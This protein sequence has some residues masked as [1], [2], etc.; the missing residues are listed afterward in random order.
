VNKPIFVQQWILALILLAAS[1]SALN[2]HVNMTFSETVHQNVTFAKDFLLVENRTYSLIEG[3]FTVENPGTETVFDSYVKVINTE[4]LV[5]DFQYVSGRYGEQIIFPK[6]NDSVSNYSNNITSSFTSMGVDIDEDGEN[7]TVRV[8]STHIIFNVT[9]EFDVLTYPL[10][11][12]SGAANLAQGGT[13]NWTFNITSNTTDGNYNE[14]VLYATLAINGTEV[15]ASQFTVGQV[16]MVLN[17]TKRNYTVLHVPELRSGQSSVFNYNVS[18]LLVEPPLDINTTYT[19]PLYETKV[20]AG[21][22]F[23]VLD[24]ATNVADVGALT[25]INITIYALPVNVSNGTA[26]ELH[27][28]T[29]Q[30]LSATGDYANVAGNGSND[31][32]WSWVTNGGS[33]PIGQSFNIS[34]QVEAPDS[35]PTSGTYPA[36]QQNL[37]YTINATASEVAVESIRARAEISFNTS[38]QIISPQD[39]LSNN[40]VTWRSVPN[41]GSYHNMTYTLEKV[42]LWVTNT[43]DPNQVSSGLNTTYYPNTQIN[44]TTSWAGSAWLFNFTDGSSDSNP[45]PIVW[46]KPYWIIQ[47]TGGQVVN[48]SITRNGTD[49][50]LKYIYVINGYW[51]E[52]EKN[53]TSA[54]NDMYSIQVHVHNRGNGHTPQNLTVTVYD[55]IPSEFAAWNF[56][57]TYNNLS[58]VSGQ[59][60]GTAYQWDVGLRTNLST[61]FAP[62]GDALGLDEFWMNYT[63]NGTGDF[64]VSDLYIVGLDPRKVD[65]AGASETVTVLSG[66]ASTSKELIY[67]G[68]V[69]FLIAINIGN[70]LM[71]SRINK[72]LD[73]KE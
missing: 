22:R 16:T 32:L 38:K 54:G 39:N 44:Q 3:V 9:S 27:N 20:L 12:T 63:V 61:S 19:N 41:V 69:V 42:T 13:F 35:V 23:N 5:T 36:V 53:V 15:T 59:F 68:I 21:E 10:Y 40:N 46:I 26:W 43:R 72:K 55:F 24:V 47:N 30:N 18:S 50:Y 29:L 6:N 51:L 70:F 52:V 73:K 14:G 56:T 1:A 45:P 60:N 2:P 33:I 65:N 37:T 71:T 7:D 67:L 8:T 62:S 66:V 25:V 58:N 48:Q 28:F 11:N 17:D 49:V 34:Y 4:N 64:K 31:R 57:P